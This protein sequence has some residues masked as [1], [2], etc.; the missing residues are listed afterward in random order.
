M[1]FADLM[2]LTVIGMYV[3]CFSES[4]EHMKAFSMMTAM[5]FPSLFDPTA[6]EQFTSLPANKILANL[7]RS[8]SLRRLQDLFARD[9]EVKAEREADL[10]TLRTKQEAKMTRIRL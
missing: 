9:A 4:T 6:W 2:L 10:A 8:E 1:P 5:R 7:S 3:G